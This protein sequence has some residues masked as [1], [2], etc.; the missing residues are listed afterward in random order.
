MPR[1]QLR[2]LVL[3]FACLL[4]AQAHAETR[5]QGKPAPDA[6][7]DR[8]TGL[9]KDEL[10]RIAPQL[11]NGPVALI[12]F[13]DMDAGQLPA[14]NIA[15]PV[16][17]SAEQ[18]TRVIA[19]PAGYPRFMPTID[20]VK[21]VAKHGDSI[22]YDWA[23][24]LA[25][26]QM[27]GRNVMTLY[28][29]PAGKADSASRITIDSE[30]GDLGRGRFLYRI[31]PRPDGSLLVLSMRLD[32]REANFV[33][34]QVAAAARSVNRSA[35]VAL[36]FSLALRVRSEAERIAG[37]AKPA[38]NPALPALRKP[39]VELAKIAPLLQRG[40]LLFFDASGDRLDQ[41]AVIGVV[42]Q[43]HDKVQAVMRDAKAFGSSLV[44]GSKAEVV[45]QAKNVT[46]FDW[47][48]D[49]PLVGVSGQMKLTDQSPQLSVDA[50]DGA[51]RGGRWVFDLQP[52][53]PDATLVTGWARF[54]FNHS[55]WLLEKLVHADAFLGQGIVGASQV[56][57][58]RAVRSRA[59]K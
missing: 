14:I 41:I 16:R 30:E 11:A 19:D 26:L 38:V 31:H 33:A 57:L 2:Y 10:D 15:V 3:A 1:T 39:Q 22:V 32:L 23:F 5:A 17:A 46:T 49:L 21:V 54:D 43:G 45:S 13:A 40:D 56:M 29:A 6:R 7:Q 59:A 58:V 34:R 28:R 47:A 8:L 20:T 52:L 9:T 27:R 25:V 42:P 51:L 36:A 53:G 35:N 44:P 55:T 4:C 37:L 50:V 18:V 12:E 24:D 48:I